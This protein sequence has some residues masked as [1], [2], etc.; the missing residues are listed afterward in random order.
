M[1]T[2]SFFG[3][4]GKDENAVAICRGIP[5]WY[6]GRTYKK[7]AP[8]WPMLK[9]SEAEF[10]QEYRE[11]ILGRLNSAEVYDELG[12]EAVLLC[13]EPFNVRCHRR[14]VAEWLEDELGV[15]IPEHSHE[16]S[17]SIPFC[18]QKRGEKKPKADKPE[19]AEKPRAR[20]KKAAQRA[21]F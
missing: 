3:E 19:E 8:T 20:T 4:G 16:R 21:L 11:K 6:K 14:L 5:R 9:M 18:D 15:E 17:D 13:W 2:S 1:K 10:E 12:T 7:L